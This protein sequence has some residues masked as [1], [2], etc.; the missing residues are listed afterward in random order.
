MAL[1]HERIP[2]RIV[3]QATP[4]Q[5]SYSTADLAVF[6]ADAA[7]AQQAAALAAT[8]GVP[9]ITAPEDTKTT[10][11]LLQ[12]DTQGLSLTDGTLSLRGDF[13]H[14]TARTKQSNLS[15]ELIVRAARLKGGAQPPIAVDATAGLGE[16]SFLL[17]AAGFEVH[18]FERDPVIAALLDDTLA[19]AA[20]DKRLAPITAR[21]HLS[22]ADSLQALYALPFQPDVVVLDPMFPARRKSASIKKKLQLL[23]QIEQPCA[24]ES[25]LLDAA[26]E[27]HPRK[28]IVKRPA[29]GPWLAERKPDYSLS[30]KAIRFDCIVCT[31]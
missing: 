29:K 16:D 11:L 25:A 4:T 1:P 17:A 31:R 2:A 14:L 23:Q 15:R 7:Y 12:L 24:D 8:I 22:E 21:M 3:E 10:R 6:A 27:A 26:I 30:G 19:R 20:A 5:T 13:T 28:I 18:L 9:L